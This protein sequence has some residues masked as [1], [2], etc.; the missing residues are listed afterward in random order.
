[1]KY[2]VCKMCVRSSMVTSVYRKPIQLQVD[3]LS[4]FFCSRN[5]DVLRS[6]PDILQTVSDHLFGILD[7]FANIRYCAC[8]YVQSC[9]CIEHH[10][11]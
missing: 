9:M 11:A 8:M 3:F 2:N 4:T 10:K 1:M 5:A 7:G 6:H